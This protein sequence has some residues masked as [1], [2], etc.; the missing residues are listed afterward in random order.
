VGD[1]LLD[2]LLAEVLAAT[3]AFLGLSRHQVAARYTRP[4]VAVPHLAT[5]GTE[6]AEAL[7]RGDFENVISRRRLVIGA[8]SGVWVCLLRLRI[9]HWMFLPDFRF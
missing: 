9:R 5:L 8:G 2:H 7:P 1:H 3:V 6:R 4:G